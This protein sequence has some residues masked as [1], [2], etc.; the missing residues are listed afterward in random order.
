MRV[1]YLF[2]ILIRLGLIEQHTATQSRKMFNQIDLTHALYVGAAGGLGSYLAYG[3]QDS[4][5]F[6]YSIS[7]PVSAG[8]AIGVANS[9]VQLIDAKWPLVQDVPF[10]ESFKSEA[11]IVIAPAATGLMTHL[12]INYGLGIPSP[13][14][15]NV[16]IGAGAELTGSYVGTKM[17]QGSASGTL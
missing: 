1:H 4:R 17:K 16:A 14:V 9:L 3:N 11:G 6:G 2:F 5:V 7:S 13:L 10:P 15:G 8:V 12:I